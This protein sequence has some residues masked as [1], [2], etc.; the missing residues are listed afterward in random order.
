VEPVA[1][2]SASRILSLSMF[3][4]PAIEICRTSGFSSTSYTTCGARVGGLALHL[5]VLEEAELVDLLRCPSADLQRV[6]R[7]AGFEPDPAADRLGV[8]AA[9]SRAR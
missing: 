4:L 8:D 6:E 1:S 2:V 3:S 7:R 5:D 9:G